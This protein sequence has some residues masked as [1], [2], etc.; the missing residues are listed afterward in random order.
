MG[1]EIK[2]GILLIL[3]EGGFIFSRFFFCVA[4]WRRPI[5]SWRIP[6]SYSFPRLR[7]KLRPKME[8]YS[9]KI[10]RGFFYSQECIAKK[11]METQQKFFGSVS[12]M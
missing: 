4:V 2:Y 10:L 3:R 7:I 6:S 8:Q 11:L 9:V 5:H 12:D 1:M